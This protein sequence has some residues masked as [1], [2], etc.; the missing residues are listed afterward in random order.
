[1][2]TRSVLVDAGLSR[3][4]R[5]KLH[6]EW[7]AHHPALVN[8][9]GVKDPYI[10]RVAELGRQAALEYLGDLV[11]KTRRELGL[12]PRPEAIVRSFARIGQATQQ[13]FRDL[14]RLADSIGAM[15]SELA[16]QGERQG[17]IEEGGQGERAE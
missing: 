2:S 6:K 1:M 8:T 10:Q 16:D 15:M 5:E 13:L 14:G 4:E 12:S 11:D 9:W 3:Q 17:A 7:F